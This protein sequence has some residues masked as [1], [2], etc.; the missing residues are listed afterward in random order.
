MRSPSACQNA[1][2]EELSDAT[3]ALA[4]S[5]NGIS[6]IWEVVLPSSRVK[7]FWPYQAHCCAH[8]LCLPCGTFIP[9]D[10]AELTRT[11]MC[12]KLVTGCPSRGRGDSVALKKG[13]SAWMTWWNDCVNPTFN[14]DSA[15]SV[16]SALRCVWKLQR[17][18]V[19]VGVG[20]CV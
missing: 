9:P 5:C 15:E 17:K 7:P 4:G 12:T 13:K 11:R 3:F 16:R 10:S 8:N 1:T 19:R 14:H 18:Q 6:D 20:T 2:N